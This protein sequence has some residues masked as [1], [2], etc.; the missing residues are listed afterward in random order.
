MFLRT[1]VKPAAFPYRNIVTNN[2]ARMMSTKM[3]PESITNIPS[4]KTLAV[5][6]PKPF[7]FHVELNRPQRY[8]AINKEMWI[9]IKDCFES[10]SSNPDCRAIVISAAGKHFTAGIDLTDM[11]KLGQDLSEIEDVAR[12]GIYLE[13]LIKLY[14][15]SISSLENCPKPV[16]S[17]IHSACIGAGI[18]MITAAD[19]RY[20]SQDAFFSVKEVEIGMAADVGTLQRFPKAVGSQSLARELCYTGRRFESSEAFNCGLISKVFPDKDSLVNGALALAE[21]IAEK[22]PIAVQATKQNVVYSQSRPNQKGL[23]HI[24]EMNKLYLQSEDFAQ[25]AAAQLTKGEKP[26]FSKL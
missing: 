21:S 7:V 10:L 2:N 17:A 12:K 23:D 19:I 4:F 18:D 14:Q 6:T 25:A 11:L 16:I 26:V 9:E 1:I 5:T 3:L 8:N 20:C 15:D 22:S 13:R 24:R